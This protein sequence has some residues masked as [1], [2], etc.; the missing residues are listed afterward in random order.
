MPEATYPLL[1]CAFLVEIEGL[2]AGSF[3]EV[4]GLSV[5]L[6][7]ESYREGGRNDMAHALPGGISYGRVVLQRGIGDA[8]LLW[9]WQAE[10]RDGRMTR[11]TVRIT[12]HDSEGRAKRDW[13]CVEALPVKWTGPELKAGDA[14]VAIERLELVHNGLRSG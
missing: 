9:R 11:H 3:A 8:E 14:Q 13:R 4:S 2:H 6:E 10:I 7:T 5:E 12:L 1:G